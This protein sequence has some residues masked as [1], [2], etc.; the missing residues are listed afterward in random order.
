MKKK[1]RRTKRKVKRSDKLTIRSLSSYKGFMPES[2]IVNMKYCAHTTVNPGAGA[3]GH[4]YV[5]CNDI[6][7]PDTTGVGHQPFGHDTMAL[8]YNHYLVLSSVLKVTI[9][10]NT[11][12]ASPTT[13]IFGIYLSDDATTGTVLSELCEQGNAKY[14]VVTDTVLS[15]GTILKD[16]T[17]THTYDPKK[18]YALTDIKDNWTRLGG[19]FGASPTTDE[20]HWDI[21]LGAADA[22]SDPGITSLWIE[23]EYKVLCTEPK[24]VAQ[25]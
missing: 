25:S 2:K 18:E 22:A 6:Y 19:V 16:R 12:V 9:A 7:D 13:C 14:K 17:L 5:S 15:Y 11:A 21:F 4:Q 23:C 24:H 3:I 10:G 1:S 20:C 8:L